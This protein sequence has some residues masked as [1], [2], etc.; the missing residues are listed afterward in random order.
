MN[1]C[2]CSWYLTRIFD[3]TGVFFF[4]SFASLLV[5]SFAKAHMFSCES[6]SYMQA[7][8][9]R[10]FRIPMLMI[11]ITCARPLLVC[12]GEMKSHFLGKLFVFVFVLLGY[13]VCVMLWHFLCCVCVV[14]VL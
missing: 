14:C 3:V 8:M 10:C 7:Y 13:F 2:D 5:R 11:L 9:T 6:D 1:L 4:V 12:N